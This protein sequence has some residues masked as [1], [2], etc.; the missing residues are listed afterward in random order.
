MRN[1]S[2]SDW[3]YLAGLI[4]GD[5][6]I[7]C[8]KRMNCGTYRIFVSISNNNVDLLRNLFNTFGGA[9]GDWETK[10]Y[11]AHH[12][13]WEAQQA[14]RIVRGILPYIDGKWEQAVLALSFPTTGTRKTRSETVETKMLQAKIYIA[15]RD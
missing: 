15:M 1:P 9:K 2:A 12:L 6:S 5:G 10:N 8:S 7:F 14:K 13:G 3:A 11:T 4:D